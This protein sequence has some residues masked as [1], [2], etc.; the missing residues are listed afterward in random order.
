MLNRQLSISS[1]RT[2]PLGAIKFVSTSKLKDDWFSLGVSSPQEADPLINCV[3]KTEFFT[4]LKRIM[5]GGLNLKIAESIEYNKKPGKPS[6]VKVVKDSTVPRDDLY[7]SGTI[8]TGPGES[9]NSV[10]KRTPKGKPKAGKPITQGKLLR[11]GGP[12]G[13]PSKLASRPAVARPVRQPMPSQPSQSTTTPAQTPS[14]R[15]VPQ[16]AAAQPRAVPQPLAAVNGLGHGR[17]DSAGRAPPPPP[18]APPPAVKK[19]AFKAL[20]DFAGQSQ[21]ELHQLAK[22]EIIEVIQKADN[23]LFLP[24]T[25]SISHTNNPP[26]WWLAKKLDGSSQGWV[27]S[28]YLTED[29][30]KPIP[31][32]APP[33]AVA[34]AVPA[35]PPSAST[36]GINGTASRAPAVKAKP[37]PPAPP[38]RPGG[39]RKPAPPPAPRD[40]AVSMGTS[41]EESGRN[42][43]EKADSGRA[44]SLAGGLA[45]ALRARQMSMQGPKE[46]DDDW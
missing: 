7:K 40:S 28:A 43:P 44:P 2:I 25:N 38:K 26:G 27:P 24:L 5:P 36:N 35:P 31:P 11:P 37:T 17:S 33:Q 20:Y 13:G 41:N 18:P 6:L 32:P 42:T 10:S 4:H 29:T 45:E 8:H 23:G 30:P 3:F 46:D 15:S 21:N 19:D 16:P 12:G 1:E 39:G 9:P 34:R 22:D 14:V